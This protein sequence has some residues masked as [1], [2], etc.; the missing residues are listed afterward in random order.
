[1]RGDARLALTA[2][3]LTGVACKRQPPEPPALKVAAAADLAFAFKELGDAYFRTTGQRVV[4]S[5][6]SS[7]LLERQIA[8]G[9]P[10]DVFAAASVS[11]VDDAIAAGACMPGSKALY[12]TGRIVV[13]AAPSAPAPP[14][15]LA[16]LADPRIRKIAIANPD[17]APY[18]R[19]A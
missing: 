1:M 14:A 11:F 9:A 8:E 7:G 12:A 13:Y 3:L 5:F 2:A 15:A 16:D 18:G 19:A 6:G 17:H 10:F 4:F